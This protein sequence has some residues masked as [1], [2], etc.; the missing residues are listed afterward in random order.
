MSFSPSKIISGGQAGVDRAA[1]DFA[2][3][4]SIPYRGF[5]PNG[6]WAED[7]RISDEYQNLTESESPDP[8]DRTRLNVRSAEAVLVVSRGEPDGG[9]KLTIALARQYG[10]PCV[11]IDLAQISLFEESAF[12]SCSELVRG[13][14]TMIAGP[15]ESKCPGIYA[16]TLAFLESVLRLD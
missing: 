10:K 7:G 6:R 4:H 15:R 12:Q 14:E 8:A 1:L 11:H 13:N 2:I 9:T 3:R 5:V 16:E